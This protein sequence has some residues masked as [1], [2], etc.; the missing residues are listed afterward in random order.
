[1]RLNDIPFNST[2]DFKFINYY[3]CPNCKNSWE[4]YWEL[5]KCNDNCSECGQSSISPVLVK[6]L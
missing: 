3:Y 5:S 4:S 1:M 2:V 6:R